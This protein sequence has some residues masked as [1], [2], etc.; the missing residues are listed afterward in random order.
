[1]D[2]LQFDFH[3]YKKALC[4]AFQTADFNV[5]IKHGKD[6][7]LDTFGEYLPFPIKDYPEEYTA[8]MNLLACKIE[9]DGLMTLQLMSKSEAKM[10][11]KITDKFFEQFYP[12][13]EQLYEIPNSRTNYGKTTHCQLFNENKIIQIMDS[14]EYQEYVQAKKSKKQQFINL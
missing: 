14:E 3:V 4:T 6:L 8:F 5:A 1:M 11:Y 2:Y 13:P 7:F 12:E 9:D 10:K